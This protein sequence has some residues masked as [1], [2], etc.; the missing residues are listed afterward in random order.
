LRGFG[1]WNLDM[2][3]GKETKIREKY[4]F[5]I[6]AAISSTPSTIRIS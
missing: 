2:R 6:S 5:E 4:G 1:L 3:I